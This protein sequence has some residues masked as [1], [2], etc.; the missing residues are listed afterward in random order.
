[1]Y[2]CN[3]IQ[4]KKHYSPQYHTTAMVLD[5]GGLYNDVESIVW[6]FN[7]HDARLHTTT[8][9]AWEAS[10]S[11]ALA[12]NG[13]TIT[14]HTYL[15]SI[16]NTRVLFF[17]VFVATAAWASIYHPTECAILKNAARRSVIGGAQQEG[18]EEGPSTA[19][20]T[21]S[22]EGSQELQ[23]SLSTLEDEQE[24]A[25]YAP[26]SQQLNYERLALDAES[27][28]TVNGLG[29]DE[30]VIAFMPA[31]EMIIPDG[32]KRSVL[33]FLLWGNHRMA[34][35]VNDFTE[36]HRVWS[37]ITAPLA[38]L[39]ALVAL[40]EVIPLD[41]TWLGVLSL[42][43]TAR[44]FSHLNV[45]GVR[46]CVSEPFDFWVPFVSFVVGAFGAMASFK[47][48]AGFCAFALST[49]C[50]FTTFV[51]LGKYSGKLCRLNLQI[52]NQRPI[53]GQY[54]TDRKS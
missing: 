39:I 54:D 17:T 48:H 31:E 53:S 5:Q 47:F 51:L 8:A 38:L 29:D 52:A 9:E 27:E 34:K 25:E 43:D 10:N 45:Q 24:G 33:C 16:A 12:D 40:T 42:P 4:P 18:V 15:R 22:H 11:T 13:S 35:H 41:L 2:Q 3:Q 6:V 21:V 7:T 44:G 1:M 46:L 14:L 36:E 30:E 19:A 32:P 49:G 23:Y 28:A 20:G 37:E 26:V 50:F